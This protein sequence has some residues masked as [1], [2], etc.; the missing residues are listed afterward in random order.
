MVGFSSRFPFP[1]TGY[2]RPASRFP[3][4]TSRCSLTQLRDDFPAR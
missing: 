3:L 4:P 1:V 2:P